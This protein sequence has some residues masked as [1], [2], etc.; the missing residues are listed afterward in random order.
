MTTLLLSA[1]DASG[2]I[3]AA[4][5]VRA[6]RTLR[7]GTRFVGLGGEAMADAGVELVAPGSDLA[8]GGFIEVLGSARRIG[9]VWR[10]MS[11]ALADTRPDLVVLVDSG[12]FN[13]PFASHVRRRSGAPI[14]YYVAPQV[15]AWRRWRIKK[16]A[17]RVDRVAVIFPFEPSHYAETSL[18]VD[19]VGHPLVESLA[20][21]AERMDAGAARRALGLDPHAPHVALLPG[22]RRNEI[23]H[24]LPV[25]LAAARE[26][27]L[28]D[29]RL[30]FVLA[31][32]P[33]ISL[34]QARE[35]VE[36]AGLPAELRLALVP[37][38]TPEAILASDAV[39]AKP[40]TVTLEATLLDRP[41]VVM[42][43]TSPTSAVIVRLA[44]RV[45]W[46]AMPNLIAGAPIVP[47]FL[48]GDA[49]PGHI[50]DALQS[51]LAGP[52]REKQ[53]AALG[54]VRRRLG[55]GGAA[56]R[57]SRIAEDL[58]GTARA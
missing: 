15:W 32:A 18:R 27:H 54:D 24:Q 53:L 20:E 31:L 21:L 35:G 38:R 2:D 51:L 6:F 7:P 46:L 37:G 36:R 49:R 58:I 41:M 23:A 39:L 12:G 11:A 45:P 1:G 40:G 56:G 43:R 28:R 48:Q 26:L 29:P 22:S 25:Q 9:S 30:H 33:S 4:G 5:F 44:V 34:A 10:K 55:N 47:E 52:A 42:G 3:H 57:A 13:L 14:M 19:F 8:I 17:R 50:A 16:L